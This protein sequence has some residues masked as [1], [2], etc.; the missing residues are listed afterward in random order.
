MFNKIVNPLTNRQ[1]STN[2]KKGKQILNNYINAL[3]GGGN[4]CSATIPPIINYRIHPSEDNFYLY[5]TD[6]MEYLL[7]HLFKYIKIGKNSPDLAYNKTIRQFIEKYNEL[8]YDR[9]L[10]LINRGPDS[11]DFTC[12]YPDFDKRNE[13]HTKWLLM[14][15]EPSSL[16]ALQIGMKLGMNVPI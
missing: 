9:A 16:R 12:R 5:K 15:L 3:N 6:S 2:T 1:V 7:E 4:T 14:S 13:Y 8:A 10:E 11:D